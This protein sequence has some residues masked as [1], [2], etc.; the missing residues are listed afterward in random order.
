MKSILVTGG[1]GFIGSHT[2]RRLVTRYAEQYH[3]VNLDRL[4]YAG[5]LVN[6]EDIAS[7]PNYEFCQGD[8]VDGDLVE[9]LFARHQF[10]AVVH[11][12]AE[13]HVDRSIQ[14][15]L[16]FVRTNVV[17]T[18]TLLHAARRHWQNDLQGRCFLQVSTDEVYGS[19]GADDP[20]FLESTPLAPRSPY[21]ASK[22]SADHLARAFHHTYGLPVKISN[23]SNNYGPNQYP[24]KLIPV[25]ILKIVQRQPIPVYGQGANVRDWLYVEDHAAALDLILHQGQVGETYN[26]GGDCERNN[27]DLVKTLCRILD[28]ELG[29]P[30]GDSEAL[31]SFVPDRLGHD[32]RYSVDFS[33][34]RQQLGWKPS[35]D[36]EEGLLRTVRWYLAHPQ[37]V[38][39]VTSPHVSTV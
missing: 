5:N 34:I 15:P 12:A 23:C 3:V 26:V 31:I 14:D 4:T 24:E 6:L 21:A 16:E 25:C 37:W 17:G 20:A 9:N 11:M 2:V 18:T 33:K 38:E 28:Q 27:L 32:F 10:Q 29:R 39:A 7:R 13:S 30:A 19:L 36:F 8:I 22:A 1:A 35:L